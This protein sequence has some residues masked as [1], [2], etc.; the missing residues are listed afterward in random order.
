M[1]IT[2]TP[3]L[4]VPAALPAPQGSPYRSPGPLDPTL[5]SRLPPPAPLR[6]R[7]LRPGLRGLTLLGSLLAHAAIL[8]TSAL[9]A[10]TSA[11]ATSAP[12]RPHHAGGAFF[13][14][15]E[16]YPGGCGFPPPESVTACFDRSVLDERVRFT[17]PAMAYGYAADPH[18]TWERIPFPLLSL[19]D[20][21]DGAEWML[22]EGLRECADTAKQAGWTGK[23]RVFVRVTYEAGGGAL[24]QVLPLDSEADHPGLLCC[25]RKSQ[26]PVASVMREG[27][28]VRYTFTDGPEGISVTPPP[29]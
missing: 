10:P 13:V 18:V 9:S 26:L 20:G 25:L 27:T 8:A 24:T 4:R 5:V 3:D 6:A 28:T 21:G 12:P 19:P 14:H 29:L 2:P 16:L 1:A 11:N 15:A 22:E 7:P 17:S 23:G